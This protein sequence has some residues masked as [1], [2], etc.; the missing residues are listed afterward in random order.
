MNH[1]S[2]EAGKNQ[3]MTTSPDKAPAGW[4]TINIG[5]SPGAIPAKLLVRARAMVTTG[6]AKEAYSQW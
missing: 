4:A 5:T 3:R 1:A 6:L 2:S